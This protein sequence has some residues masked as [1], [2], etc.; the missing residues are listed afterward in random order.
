MVSTREKK[1]QQK[2]QLNETSYYV[3]LGNGAYV[4]A[5]EKETLEQQAN[6]QHNDF[7]SFV[8]CA[9]QNQVIEY[10]IDDKIRRALDNAFSTVENRMHE[11]IV[12]AMYKMVIPRVEMVVRSIT[13]SS[14]CKILTEG[15]SLG[16]LVTLRSYRPLVD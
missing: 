6:G 10:N 12:T 7:E 9:S 4:N 5:M 13:G 14:G 1:N 8:D 16:T 11:V 3:I 15:V 2:K